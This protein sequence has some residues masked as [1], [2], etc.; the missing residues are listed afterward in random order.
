MPWVGAFVD[1]TVC[2]R[3]RGAYDH[4]SNGGGRRFQRAEW[5][6]HQSETLERRWGLYVPYVVR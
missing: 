5:R 6:L 3:Y 1:R 4:V 2:R